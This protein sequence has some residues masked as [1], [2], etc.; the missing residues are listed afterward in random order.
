[1]LFR[2]VYSY[3]NKKFIILNSNIGTV[4]YTTGHIKINNLRTSLYDNYIS[5]YMVPMNKDVMI[6][7]D[8]I[9]LI[10]PADVT[11]NV[12]VATT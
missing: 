12:T 5:I 10:D 8:K 2:S 3:I 9:L 6:N 7:Q 11:I 1:M 4:D